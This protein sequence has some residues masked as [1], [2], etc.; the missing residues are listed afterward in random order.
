M[1]NNLANFCRGYLTPLTVERRKDPK[2]Q[3]LASYIVRI[4]AR[5]GGEQN[6]CSNRNKILHSDT[7]T[8]V[9]TH[10]TFSDHLS[11]VWGISES[12]KLLPKISVFELMT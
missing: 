1:V 3:L 4:T 11:G 5:E 8:D 7:G 2:N 6:L 12:L 10:E 9:I